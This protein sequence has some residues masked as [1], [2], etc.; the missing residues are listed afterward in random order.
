MLLHVYAR[1]DK[2][3]EE[4]KMGLIVYVQSK[5][6]VQAWAENENFVMKTQGF[7]KRSFH[8]TMRK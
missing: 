3:F 4:R 2:M 6:Y 5:R 7:K 1:D 8:D